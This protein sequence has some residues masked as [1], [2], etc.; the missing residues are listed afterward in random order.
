MTGMLSPPVEAGAVQARAMDW[1]PAV[2]EDRVGAL[3]VVTGV[4]DR[5]LEGAPRP[6]AFCARTST[7]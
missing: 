4:T 1:F 5:M 2:A 3:A 6:A 7:L